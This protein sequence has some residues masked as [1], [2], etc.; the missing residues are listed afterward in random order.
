MLTSRAVITANIDHALTICTAGHNIIL[1]NSQHRHMR[2]YSYSHSTGECIEALRGGVR[3][4]RS[5]DSKWQSVCNSNPICQTLEPT[6]YT[7]VT[8]DSPMFNSRNLRLS[9]FAKQLMPCREMHSKVEAPA[10][11]LGSS[12]QV[13]R[14]ADHTRH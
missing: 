12:G 2:D 13:S 11:L 14:N 6:L 5:H 7:L 9:L 3:V 1:L 8:R 4:S 10:S